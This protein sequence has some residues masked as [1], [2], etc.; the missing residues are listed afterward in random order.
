MKQ[1]IIKDV[2]SSSMP[3]ADN[4]YA[5]SFRWLLYTNNHP[6]V[7]VWMKRLKTDYIKKQIHLEIYED[8]TGKTSELLNALSDYQNKEVLVLDHLDSKKKVQFTLFF[9]GLSVTQHTA[10]YDYGS[11]EVLTHKVMIEYTKMER[12]VPG[13]KLGVSSRGVGN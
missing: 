9:S 5:R 4:L 10:K 12:K 13:P 11:S 3:E 2:T 8:T 7:H 1:L 6:D